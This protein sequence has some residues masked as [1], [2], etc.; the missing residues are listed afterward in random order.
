VLPAHIIRNLIGFRDPRQPDELPLSPNLPNSFMVRGR[1]YRVLNLHY[2][3]EFLELAIHV[4]NA[5]RV[6]VEGTWSGS[7]RAVAVKDARGT[8]VSLEGT[9]SRW[10]F[11][12]SNHQQY[13]VRIEGISQ[14]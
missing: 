4:L 1:T 10:Q 8:N 7:F 5:Q 13:F 2:C 11:E 14:V 6:R 3:S 9:G 12:G